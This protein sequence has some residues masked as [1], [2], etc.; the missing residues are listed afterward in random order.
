MLQALILAIF[1]LVALPSL[2]MPFK[3]DKAQVLCEV[4]TKRMTIGDRVGIFTSDRQLAAIGEVSEIRT[5]S[6]LVKITKKWGSLYRTY[7]MEIIPDE[8]A[9]DPE[10]F[11]KIL[12]PLPELSW[13]ANIGLYSLGVGDGFIGPSVEGLIRWWWKRS[14]FVIGRFHYINGS[15]E[16]SDNLGNAGTQKVSISTYG[17]S[18]GMSELIS[19]FDQLA[20]RFEGDLGFSNTAVTLSGNFDEKKV[21]ND[22]I[23][24]GA[25]I[26]ARAGVSAIWRREGLEPELG[27]N[28]LRLHAS[29]D[30][31]LFVGVSQSL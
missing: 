23:T 14:L 20:V 4:Q 1:G 2:A 17:L 16:A 10:K 7:E 30:F 26:Y 8:Q 22:R 5:N 28:Y 21:L 6:R 18:G 15:G 24:D 13:G 27:F 11:F 9:N 3:C 29:N 12:T 25:G 19:L 31:G